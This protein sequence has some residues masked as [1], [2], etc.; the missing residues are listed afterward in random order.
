MKVIFLK[1]YEKHEEGDLVEVKRGYAQNF[2]ITQ[3]I[4]VLA[5]KKALENWEK[6]KEARE[7]KKKKQ[8]EES[9]KIVEKIN[10]VD[11]VFKLKAKEDGK[12]FGSI[13]KEDI[14]K[15]LKTKTGAEIKK[16]N[17]EVENIKETGVF[18]AKAVFGKDI[19]ASFRVNVEKE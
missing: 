6:D 18:E 15:E 12:A 10:D 17:I 1:D 16:Q 2:L 19:T 9:K 14:V 3:K 11:L 8:V 7:E 13:T 4:A 5:D